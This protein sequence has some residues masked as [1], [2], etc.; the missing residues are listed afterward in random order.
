[1]KIM[2][3]NTTSYLIG[4]KV[5][6]SVLVMPLLIIFGVAFGIVGGLLVALGGTS[7]FTTTEFIRGL[8]DPIRDFD[9]II[10]FIKSL[11]FAFIITSISAY[12]GFHTTG[13]VVGVGQASTRAVVYS[14]IVV[15]IADFLIAA[16]LL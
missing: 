16:L 14:S 15:I 6:A 4:P 1:M 9:T 8:Q 13:G 5:L 12:Q 10:M 2:G 7:G 11:S 3:V